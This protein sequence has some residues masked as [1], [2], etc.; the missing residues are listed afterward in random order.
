MK[1]ILSFL[2][3]LILTVGVVLTPCSSVYANALIDPGNGVTGKLIDMTNYFSDLAQYNA[4]NGTGVP[5][6][7]TFDSLFNNIENN[8]ANQ[9]SFF[10]MLFTCIY[11][12]CERYEAVTGEKI[13]DLNQ[14]V[15]QLTTHIVHGDDNE[16][17]SILTWILNVANE[18]GFDYVNDTGNSNPSSTDIADYIKGFKIPSNVL[19]NIFNLTKDMVNDSGF[20]ISGNPSFFNTPS[21]PYISFNNVTN[22]T[23]YN[24]NAFKSGFSLNS[25]LSNINTL[26]PS[27]I[28][29]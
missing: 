19:D 3:A 24:I 11:T 12:A 18:L 22:N 20:S 26:Y 5:S 28:S 13:T 1:R 4:Q 17:K 6:Q 15:S 7:S 27:T 25:Y 21:E 14:F 16:S 8:P 23:N 10:V 2:S 29:L 9:M